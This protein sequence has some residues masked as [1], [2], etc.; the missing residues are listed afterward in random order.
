MRLLT[1]G[2]VFAASGERYAKAIAAAVPADVELVVTDAPP[3]GR[4]ATLFRELAAT[5]PSA[6]VDAAREACREPLLTV[7]LHN[8]WIAD[9]CFLPGRSG[10]EDA[11]SLMASGS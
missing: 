3:L 6:A 2:L 5:V 11:T 1:P 9:I 10:V 4:A 7:K 8:R